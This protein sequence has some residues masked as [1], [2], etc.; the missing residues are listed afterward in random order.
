MPPELL[1]GQ[2][3]LA[4]PALDVWAI[5]IMTYMMLVGEYPFK[6]ETTSEVK[7]AIKDQEIK[8]PVEI[9]ITDEAKELISKMLQ[10]K[11]ENRLK[12]LDFESLKWF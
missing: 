10:K 1:S 8:F 4:D 9:S 5:G 3:T 2:S 6:G 7:K 11:P 12:M